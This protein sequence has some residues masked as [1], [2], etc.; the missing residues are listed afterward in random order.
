MEVELKDLVRKVKGPVAK[1]TRIL[2]KRRSVKSIENDV[3]ERLRKGELKPEHCDDCADF[4]K[5]AYKR[6]M[7][8]V[9]N[10]IQEEDERMGKM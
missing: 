9:R 5:L 8:I 2:H 6:Q 1:A 7:Q 3:F 10:L 4:P